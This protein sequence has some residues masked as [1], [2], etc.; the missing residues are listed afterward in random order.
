MKVADWLDYCGTLRDFLDPQEFE[1]N[2]YRDEFM[3]LQDYAA[4]CD[5]W[6]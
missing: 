2:E 5:E 6:C 4:Y 1:N 3:L